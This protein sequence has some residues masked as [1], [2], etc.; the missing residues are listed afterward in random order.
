MRSLHIHSRADATLSEMRSLI[1]R[2]KIAES[3][4]P[5]IKDEAQKIFK[6]EVKAVRRLIKKNLAGITDGRELRGTD[7]LYQDLQ[8]FYFGEFTET[9]YAT[10]LPVIRQYA[11]KIYTQATLEVGFPT[12]FT[13]ELEEFIEGYVQVMSNRHAKVSRQ[14]L[15]AIIS[16]AEF[17][18]LQNLLDIELEKWLKSRAERVARLEVTEGNGAFSKFGYMAAGV[19]NL[20]WVTSGKETCPF[21]KR[22]SGTVVGTTERFVEAGD[23]VNAVVDEGQEEPAPLV[24]RHNVGH[25][26]L[27]SFCDCFISPSL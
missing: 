25:P 19:M 27:H 10:M 11:T 17:T 18:E 1:D 21:C 13:R 2:K 20:R 12:D 4:L 8:E 6:R 14:K 24:A 9:I 22:L 5:K 15:Q 16:V 23:S 3:T 26:P 7:S